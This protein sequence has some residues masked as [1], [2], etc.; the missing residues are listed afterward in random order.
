MSDRKRYD[1]DLG[2]QD[3]AREGVAK[4]REPSFSRI[5]NPTRTVVSVH[6]LT[7]SFPEKHFLLQL[8]IQSCSF[9]YA[10]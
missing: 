2:P 1:S 10:T 3:R 5:A 4:G 9:L 6:F 7:A 8:N